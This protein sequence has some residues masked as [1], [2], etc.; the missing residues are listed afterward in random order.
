MFLYNSKW[1]IILLAIMVV[2]SCRRKPDA[3]PTVAGNVKLQFENVVNGQPLKIDNQVYVNDNGDSFTV[4][5]YRYYISNIKL[6]AADGTEFA[7]PESYHLVKE[8][9]AQ[10]KEILISDVRAGNYTKIKFL[11]GV[12][13]LR[14]VS[15]AQSG[16]LDPKNMMFWD[17]DSGYIMA[18]LEGTATKTGDNLVF[19]MSGFKP[20][21]NTL[22]W[23]TLD[24]PDDMAVSKDHTPK[25]HLRS[26]LAEWFRT[27]H[28]IRF[29]DMTIVAGGDNAVKLADNYADMFRVDHID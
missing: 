17:W 22:R 4:K 19:H 20:P 11:V 1:T 26:D 9:N 2:A 12:D 18:M 25:I 5:K 23:I 6:V 15:G 24:L 14:N 29:E 3:E 7:Q 27:P 21:Y 10:S 28:L 16:A 13:S 8:E